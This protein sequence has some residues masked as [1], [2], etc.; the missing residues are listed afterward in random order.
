MMSVWT[1]RIDTVR[2]LLATDVDWRTQKLARCDT[3]YMIA[4]LQ[5]Y[6]RKPLN[7][8]PMYKMLQKIGIDNRDAVATDDTE[9][10]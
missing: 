3:V 5:A 4:I 9:T 6:F 7:C 2:I 10:I 8:Y 1:F